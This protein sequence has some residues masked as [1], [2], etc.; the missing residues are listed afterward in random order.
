MYGPRPQGFLGTKYD[1]LGFKVQALASTTM[2]MLL[3]F[4]NIAHVFQVQPELSTLSIILFACCL[5][6]V[7]TRL[8]LSL[9]PSA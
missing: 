3:I 7:L 5:P 1:V 6:A 8:V 4:V 2:K 9:T